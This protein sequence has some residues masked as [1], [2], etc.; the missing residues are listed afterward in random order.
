MR[1]IGVCE[2]ARARTPTPR[3][4]AR[5]YTDSKAYI[6]EMDE[7]VL[8]TSSVSW[9][10]WWLLR[11]WSVV[12]V[13]RQNLKKCLVFFEVSW[14]QGSLGGALDGASSAGFSFGFFCFGGGGVGT[15]YSFQE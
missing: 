4:A 5:I 6:Q 10:N 2:I 11:S 12:K 15:L 8:S 14:G 1:P 9:F 13:G 3:K 7:G